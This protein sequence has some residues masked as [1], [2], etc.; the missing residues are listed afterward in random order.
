ML[1]GGT[2]SHLNAH[3]TT[4]GSNV[5]KSIYAGEKPNGTDGG[6][7][8]K[9]TASGLDTLEAEIAEITL[10]YLTGLDNVTGQHSAEDGPA[11]DDDFR[12]QLVACADKLIGLRLVAT[13]RHFVASVP[14]RLSGSALKP[15]D[16]ALHPCYSWSDITK[17]ILDE[18]VSTA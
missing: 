1:N 15:S 9:P 18:C 3:G 4:S 7:S 8:G 12:R 5:E 13:Y 11:P 2:T 16:W 17:A 6:V 14:E 10:Q